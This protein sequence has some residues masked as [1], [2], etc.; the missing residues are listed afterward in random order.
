MSLPLAQSLEDV[1]P[2]HQMCREG[3]LYDV[4]RWIG[5]R[6][7]L[8]SAPQAIPKGLRPKTALQIAVE[9]GQHS[10]AFLLLSNGYRLELER[11]AP[12]DLALHVRRWDLADL[13][14]SV[15]LRMDFD[16]SLQCTRP[17]PSKNARALGDRSRRGSRGRLPMS[18]FS[19]TRACARGKLRDMSEKTTE[20][21]G[22][23]CR[24]RRAL[25]RSSGAMSRR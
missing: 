6:K 15:S 9:T 7:P 8:Q 5:E 11:Y 22:C 18:S 3:R 23:H 14:Y 16:T 12:L 2:L 21:G 17:F 20:T 24:A 1:R 13:L 10:L 19:K 4:E 25:S